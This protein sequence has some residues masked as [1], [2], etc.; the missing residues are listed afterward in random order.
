MLAGTEATS[1][2]EEASVSSRSKY[3]YLLSSIPVS[4]QLARPYIQLI[5][6][7]RR[8]HP[9]FDQYHLLLLPGHLL[10]PQSRQHLLFHH[11]H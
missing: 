9:D 3:D 8:N 11:H 7:S 5:S 4:S 6:S 2:L 1:G 10:H